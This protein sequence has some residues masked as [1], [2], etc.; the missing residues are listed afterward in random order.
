MEREQVTLQITRMGFHGEAEALYQGKPVYLS[1]CIPGEEVLAELL[2][3]RRKDHL[4]GRVLKILSPSP[5]RISSPCPYFGPCSGCQWQHIDYA[6]QLELKRKLVAE[7]LGL[8]GG[9]ADPPVNPTIPCEEPWHYRNHARFSIGPSPGEGQVGF[10]NR[11]THKFVRIDRCL[12]MHPAISEVLT[13]LQD[14]CTETTQ[15]SVRYGEGT[16]SLLIQPPLK[17][18][19]IPL[20]SGQ[21]HYQE[22]LLGR[23]FRIAASS[24]FQVNTRQTERVIEL[25][26]TRLGTTG[27]EFL[28]DAYAGVGTFAVLLAPYVRTALAIEESASAIADAATNAAGLTNLRFVKGK[29]EDALK[30]LKEKPDAIILDPPRKGCH[31]EAL[32]AV[33]ALAPKRVLYISC[34]PAALARDLRILAD[35]GYL[36]EEVQPVDMF[37]QTYH[38]ECIALLTHKR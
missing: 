18:P 14:R 6:Y 12:L 1:Q 32:A 16:G 11:F 19:E 2:P 22:A 7:Q 36:L 9:F 10:V 8:V 37:P 17:N 27:Q 4:V 23:E 30:E 38:L 26:R 34:E 24:F 5:H 28:V 25:L 35:C 20:K 29:T 31:P 21:H 33:G 13:N 3:T 15:V